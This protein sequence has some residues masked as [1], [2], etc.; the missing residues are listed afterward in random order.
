MTKRIDAN[1]HWPVDEAELRAAR[2]RE[3]WAGVRRGYAIGTALGV[4]LAIVYAL[5]VFGGK[6]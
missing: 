1:W 2:R 6:P 4:L 5:V 3:F